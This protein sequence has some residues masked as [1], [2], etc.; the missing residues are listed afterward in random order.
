MASGAKDPSN[1]VEIP[2]QLIEDAEGKDQ[3]ALETVDD[4]VSSTDLLVPQQ[5]EESTPTSPVVEEK[6]RSSRDDHGSSNGLQ[7]QPTNQQQQKSSPL[8]AKEDAAKIFTAAS[9]RGESLAKFQT[10][11]GD[12]QD[13]QKNERI[14][15]TVEQKSP[16][17][18]D[19]L[20]KGTPMSSGS[21]EFV[22]V[23][24]EANNNNVH[25]VEIAIGHNRRPAQKHLTLEE[26]HPAE[27]EMHKMTV[28][29]EFKSRWQPQIKAFLLE[30]YEKNAETNLAVDGVVFNI[31]GDDSTVENRFDKLLNRRNRV[32]TIL[33]I[34]ASE[35]NRN[36]NEPN[37][38]AWLKQQVLI[39]ALDYFLEQLSA[40]QWHTHKR[41][42][43]R[44]IFQ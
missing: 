33:D 30:N 1:G 18:S 3:P 6:D 27:S 9:P 19:Q 29:E 32:K 36:S 35:V 10:D 17:Q 37:V 22:I 43:K 28:K 4:A 8:G 25:R 23:T 12:A 2:L 13:D 21:D 40:G 7:N 34:K 14:L 5:V 16:K 11:S 39:M 24:P 15:E 31:K 20:Q 38:L 26:I 42:H 41:V 44:G